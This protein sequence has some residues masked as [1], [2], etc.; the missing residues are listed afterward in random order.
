MAA[1]CCC[2]C[3]APGGH[4][5]TGIWYPAGM[6]MVLSKM[7]FPNPVCEAGMF[8]ASQFI[9]VDWRLLPP[10]SVYIDSTP[11]CRR[12]R[13]GGVQGGGPGLN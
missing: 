3:C 2:C 8:A 13:P 11:G 12:E 4:P 1:S 10:A 7:K 6:P 5:S 9:G